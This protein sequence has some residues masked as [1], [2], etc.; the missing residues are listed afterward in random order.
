MSPSGRSLR[1]Q[2]LHPWLLCLGWCLAACQSSF[3][4]WEPTPLGSSLSAS[5]AGP[6]LESAWGELASERPEEALALLAPLDLDP[7]RVPFSVLDLEARARAARTRGDQRSLAAERARLQELATRR[8][9]AAPLVLLARL[10]PDQDAARSLVDQALE[11]EPE[12]PDALVAR[13]VLSL[14]GGE[15][16]RW[17]TARSAV[18]AALRTDPGHLGARRLE[19]WML[20]QEGHPN[21]QAALGAWL[22]AS[23]SDPRVR[24]AQRISA[25]LD[26][27]T[28]ELQEGRSEVAL[29]QLAGLR[30]TS[31][32]RPRRLMLEAACWV[33]LGSPERARA[34]AQAAAAAAP[35]DSLPWVH[36]ALL[37]QGEDPEQAMQL[38]ERVTSMGAESGALGGVLQS[39]RA[40]VRSSRLEAEERESAGT[41]QP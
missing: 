10:A 16:L 23:L 4:S 1:P 12:Q 18:E 33:D 6:T 37:V 14:E 5:E 38:W 3:R 19:A 9:D 22:T 31:E 21:A 29:E 27:V 15:R 32:E 7:L 41:G 36:L 30:G 11:R 8:G 25:L 17:Q 35:E 34:C 39:L 28:L 2:A 26:L 20:A 24:E 13:A 40:R